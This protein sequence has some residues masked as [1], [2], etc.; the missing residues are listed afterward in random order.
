MVT[1]HILYDHAVFLSN[2][3]YQQKYHQNIDIQSEIEQP[4][5]HM[6]ALGSSSIEDQ[7]ALLPERVACLHDQNTPIVASNGV[8]V[9]DRLHFFYW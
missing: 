7:A 3:E 6:L 5:V 2:E 9:T 1:V 8:E 4:E